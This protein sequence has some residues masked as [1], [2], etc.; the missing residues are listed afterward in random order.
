MPDVYF[1]VDPLNGNDTTGTG[2]WNAPVKTLNKAAGPS[3]IFVNTMTTTGY[4]ILVLMPGLYR[5][6]LN[7]GLPTTAAAQVIIQGDQYGLYQWTAGAPPSAVRS[8][9]VDLRGWTTAVTP[10]VANSLF[11]CTKQYVTIRNVKFTGGGAGNPACF[12]V[13]SVYQIAFENCTFV[14]NRLKP[15][16]GWVAGTSS[17]LQMTFDRC[18][19]YGPSASSFGIDFRMPANATEYNV[20]AV[21]KNCMFVGLSVGIRLVNVGGTGANYATGLIVQNNKFV[22]CGVGFAVAYTAVVLT[23]PSLVFG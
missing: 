19:F 23:N 13:S 15:T 4:N 5:D 8:G 11:A 6:T 22:N 3:G 21:V 14:S 1:F 9:L 20:V 18:A 10:N 12:D 17:G 7:F 16:C 2:A